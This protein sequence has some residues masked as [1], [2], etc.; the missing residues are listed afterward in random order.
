MNQTLR[1]LRVIGSPFCDG[2]S[3]EIPTDACEVDALYKYAV[4]NK[5]GLLFL[6]SLSESNTLDAHEMRSLWNQELER[7][8]KQ[9]ITAVRISTHLNSQNVDYVLFK[10][11]FHFP[12]TPNDV[13]VLIFDSEGPYNQFL[14]YIPSVGYRRIEEIPSPSEVMFHDLRESDHEDMKTK[15]IFDVDLYR[16]AGASYVI[17]LDKRKLRKYVTTTEIDGNKVVVFIPEAELLTI[18]T[19]A[20]IPEQI[21]TLL[22]YYASLYYLHS[23]FD[24]DKFIRIAQENSAVYPLR[25]HFSIAAAL[26]QSAH[27]FVPEPVE[28]ILSRIGSLERETSA[29]ESNAMDMPYRC[30]KSATLRTM[31]QKSKEDVFRRS[32]TRQL[33]SMVKNP[34]LTKWVIQNIIWRRTR[35]T[36]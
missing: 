35:E 16:E 19:H 31:L 15:D 10:S 13:D 1:L 17:Y 14:E 25:I 36:Y 27:G 9:K 12:A 33:L 34:E 4:R 5:I 26:H 11:L 7:H 24:I 6:Q 18:I 29:L 22:V 8:Q 21:L 2:R 30:S 20:I 23:N 28:A 32:M 3:D